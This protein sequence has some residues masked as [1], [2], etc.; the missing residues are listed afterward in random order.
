MRKKLFINPAV[1]GRLVWRTLLYFGACMF[2][3]IT[4]IALVRTWQQPNGFV[5]RHLMETIQDHAGILLCVSIVLPLALYDMLRISNRIAGPVFRL[6]RELCRLADGEQVE[7]L[8][9][10]PDDCWHD[11][12][13]EFNRVAAAHQR[14]RSGDRQMADARPQADEAAVAVSEQ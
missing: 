6:Q 8:R 12:A 7:P 5:F 9:F 2:L 13:D 3:L 14:S 4:P 1:Q 11:V 10:R